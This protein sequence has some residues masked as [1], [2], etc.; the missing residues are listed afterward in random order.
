M[1]QLQHSK[2]AKAME[3]IGISG[4]KV[5]AGLQH[6]MY[7]TKNGGKFTL[8]GAVDHL[9][10]VRENYS[11]SSNLSRISEKMRVGFR[12]PK[13]YT[14]NVD[15]EIEKMGED[16]EM[17]KIP[18]NT[19]DTHCNDTH[20]LCDDED[21]YLFSSEGQ[22]EDNIEYADDY[23]GPKP[24]DISP[25]VSPDNEY[26]YQNHNDFVVVSLESPKNDHRETNPPVKRAKT[27]SNFLHTFGKSIFGLFQ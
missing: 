18:K 22:S 14:V 10:T 8:K 2:H 16:L 1:L 27:E 21:E 20:V 17:G 19:Y 25:P 13:T 9:L 11:K 5:F 3:F 24:M 15:K 23:Y 6:D 12:D 4:E 7:K 26:G